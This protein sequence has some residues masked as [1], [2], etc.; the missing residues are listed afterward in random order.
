MKSLYKPNDNTIIRSVFIDTKTMPA[1][2]SKVLQYAVYID[3]ELA[4]S[5]NNSDDAYNY[6]NQQLCK[7]ANDATIWDNWVEEEVDFCGI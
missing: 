4:Y 5:T 1:I 6:A 7:Y 3:G 2:I